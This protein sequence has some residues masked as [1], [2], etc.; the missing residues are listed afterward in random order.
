[1]SRCAAALILA[2]WALMFSRD[3]G[4][5]DPRWEVVSSHDQEW[6]CEE[7]RAFEVERAALGEIGSA[8]A[9]QS[10]ENP[11]RQKAYARA[12]SQL[13]ARYRCERE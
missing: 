13:R 2:G 7:V 8:L 11:I 5:S 3:P 10:A 12:V 9:Q 6:V 4:A 1:M